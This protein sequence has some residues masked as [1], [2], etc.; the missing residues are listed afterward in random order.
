[1]QLKY[2]KQRNRTFGLFLHLAHFHL[3]KSLPLYEH[4]QNNLEH[5][6]HQHWSKKEH[7]R[8]VQL[9]CLKLS[10]FNRDLQITMRDEGRR[11]QEVTSTTT[12]PPPTPIHSITQAVNSSL[13]ACKVSFSRTQ[14]RKFVRRE[15]LLFRDSNK[16]LCISVCPI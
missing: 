13:Y 2:N 16:D 9:S 12:P 11:E 4:L 10:Y 6:L 14:K 8:Q 5:F 7:K 3:G 15:F 1:M